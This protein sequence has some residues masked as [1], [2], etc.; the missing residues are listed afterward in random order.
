MEPDRDIA[1]LESSSRVRSSRSARREDFC[2]DPS[3]EAVLAENLRQKKIPRLDALRAISALIVVL[4]HFGV[5]ALPAG[6]GVM[7]FFVIS[8]FLITW[9]LLIETERTG[10]VALG[11]FYFRRTFR[12]FPAFYVFWAVTVVG[13]LVKHRSI[14]WGQAVATLFYVGN[15]Y[16]GLNHYPETGLSHA[17]SLGVEEQYYLLWPAVAMLLARRPRLLFQITCGAILLVWVYRGVLVFRGMPQEYIYTAFDTRIDHLLIGCAVAIALR[18][19][20]L[21]A[22]WRIVC[23]RAGYAL[24]TLA[25]L[26]VSSAAELVWRSDY[27]DTIGFI[28]IRF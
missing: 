13:M 11:H 17:W 3:P 5:L 26:T 19:G 18:F 22:L 1:T 28:V 27:R 24:L 21:S 6:L 10:T 4:F 20:Y 23:A 25:G 9:L 2:A 15:Y 14:L 16:Q 8:G 12:I 7:T